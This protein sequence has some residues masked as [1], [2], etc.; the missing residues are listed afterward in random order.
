MFG[1]LKPNKTFAIGFFL[2]IIAMASPLFIQ[3]SR[4][5]SRH[6]KQDTTLRKM[7]EYQIAVSSLS[8]AQKNG[9]KYA[10][11]GLIKLSDGK[12][13]LVGDEITNKNLINQH[14]IEVRRIDY[15]I[16]DVKKMIVAAA[17]QDILAKLN[18]AEKML[19]IDNFARVVR[20]ERD[21]FYLIMDKKKLSEYVFKYGTE[22][23]SCQKQKNAK[24]SE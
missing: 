13:H 22:C 7:Q 8:E 18:K 24:K 20:N 11:W 12:F 17:M 21:E 19:I 1:Q 5:L 3:Y 15:E 9:L 6:K 23:D 4:N 2:W 16:L 14:K 10:E